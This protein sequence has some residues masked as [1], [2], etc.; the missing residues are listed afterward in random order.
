MKISTRKELV[1]LL[2]QKKPEILNNARA[3]QYRTQPL[4]IEAAT[5]AIH[6]VYKELK[7]EKAPAI[8]KTGSPMASMLLVLFL[9]YTKLNTEMNEKVWISALKQLQVDTL[10]FF[11]VRDGDRVR[12]T[13]IADHLDRDLDEQAVNFKSVLDTNLEDLASKNTE[14]V[15]GV[16]KHSYFK[17]AVIDLVDTIYDNK[18]ILVN[19]PQEL[20]K[21]REAL[22]KFVAELFETDSAGFKAAQNS[23]FLARVRNFYGIIKDGYR[24]SDTTD[25]LALLNVNVRGSQNAFLCE[26]M[27][28]YEKE[29]DVIVT[30]RRGFYNLFKSTFNTF[31][32]EKFAIT[33]EFPTDIRV[34][35]VDNRLH[36]DNG[37]VVQF[38]DGFCIYAF[39]G[40]S[41]PWGWIEDRNQI[42]VEAID[43]QNNQE[44]KRVMISL[45]GQSRYILDSGA[46][47]IAEDDWGIL[48][49]KVIQPT[50]R[51]EQGQELYM[52]KVV[53]ST[54]E[55]DGTY[56]DY[57]LTP[58]HE[59]YDLATQQI[60]NKRPT[61]PLEAIASTFHV[62]YKGFV[63]VLGRQGDILLMEKPENEEPNNTY[64]PLT[65]EEY[66]H[67]MNAQS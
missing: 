7:V 21:N 48:F 15:F 47:K 25:A 4:E 38:P 45:Y 53:N 44:L 65:A 58:W 23:Q 13:D 27:D 63:K 56:K 37:P 19:N 28:F 33:C 24:D 46:E 50:S 2:N 31:F 42:T 34:N 52:V 18:D 6:T 43:K 14:G 22:K 30:K 66:K 60:I 16:R 36:S 32:F 49:R 17:K 20:P 29:L 57:F 11:A 5:A 3:L 35:R 67:V 8:I 12:S 1:D 10:R 54:P 40:L 61:S 62:P 51:W 64:R 59:T 26:F 41:I 55:P 39:R 9:K